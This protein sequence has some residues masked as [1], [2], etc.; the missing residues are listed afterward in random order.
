MESIG[1]MP[2]FGKGLDTKKG[3]LTERQRSDGYREYAGMLKTE[4]QGIPVY[5][6]Y[7]IL[8]GSNGVIYVAY[9]DLTSEDET[10]QFIDQI[11]STIRWK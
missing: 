9:I 1:R 6:P 8:C 2:Q 3:N 10:N 5:G 11:V 7:R 4:V